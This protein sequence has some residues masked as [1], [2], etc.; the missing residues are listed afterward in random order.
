MRYLYITAIILVGTAFNSAAQQLPQFTQYMYNTI[1]INPA[2]AG[3]RN[4]LNITGLHR[5][6]WVGLEGGPETQT[7]SIHSPLKNERVG[8]GLSVIN[9]K[10]GY[11]NYTYIYGDFSYTLP[12]NDDD[13]KLAF[14]LKG[15]FS[16]YNLDDEPSTLS[17]PYFTQEFNKWTPNFGIGFYLHTNKW[18]V[19]ASVPKVINNNNNEFQEFVAL[20]QNHFYLTTGY[21]FDINENFKLRP[22]AL[23]KVTEGAPLSLDLTGT[24]IFYEKLYLGVNFRTDDSVGAFADFQALDW[25]RIGY[26]YDLTTS[27]LAPYAGGTH[28]I[29]LIFEFKSK[30]GRYKS[31]RFF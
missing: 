25:A 24:A 14:G 17:D 2:Y 23:A 6:Q 29:L 13:L 15:G 19:G 3:S 26:G 21:V 9:D 30:V 31:P 22:S 27:E 7:L 11:E 4:A 10:A 18:Y 8:L 28:E 5:S 12:L 20:E 16:Y 1:S